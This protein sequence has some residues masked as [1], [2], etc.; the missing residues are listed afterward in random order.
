M[1]FASKKADI[2][3][4]DGASLDSALA[5][6]THMGIGAHPD[7][8]EIMAFHG[9]LE[10]SLSG[11][12]GFLGVVVSDGAGSPRQGAYAAVTDEQMQNIRIKEQQ[13]AAAI[14]GYSAAIVLG[15]PTAT[16]KDPKNNGAFQDIHALLEAARP[17]VVYTHNLADKHDT[18]VAV[19]LRAIR[20]MRE[21]PAEKRPKAVYGCEVWR[22]LDWMD[23][24]DKA[25]LN[26]S[27]QDDLASSLIRVHDS[28]VAGG[29]RYDLATLGRRRAN[30]TYFAAHATDT[31]DMLIY[32]MDLTPL[33]TG[34][35]KDISAF[36]A[37]HAQK[38]ARDISDRLARLS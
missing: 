36:V 30:A 25:A 33:V 23:D 12:R 24:A 2:F 3:I 29:K 6:T 11:K 4:P 32:A 20:A 27:G 13:K 22:G 31:A 19:A 10:G 21:L 18:H 15:H 14:G 28:Q 16:L 9:I 17:S 26:V 5:R 38:F 34:P 1:E 35:E 37:S 7:D 8:L